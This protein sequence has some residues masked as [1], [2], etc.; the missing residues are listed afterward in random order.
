MR[1]R[2]INRFRDMKAQG[3]PVREPGECWD[4]D[5]ARLKEINGAGYGILVEAVEMPAERNESDS[6]PSFEPDTGKYTKAELLAQA[7]A[8]NVSV[9]PKATKAEI[10]ALIAKE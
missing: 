5:E 7:E 3:R 2:C 10:A 4:A 8:L 6:K 9:P 1:I